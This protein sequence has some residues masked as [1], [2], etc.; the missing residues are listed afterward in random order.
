MKNLLLAFFLF[1][2]SFN[3][4][5][6]VAE[7]IDWSNL[8]TFTAKSFEFKSDSVTYKCS[9][10]KFVV[11]DSESGLSG[12][13]LMGEANYEI[14][15]AGIKDKAFCAMVRLSPED[16]DTLIKIE[17]KTV[18]SDNGFKSHSKLVL[19]LIFKRSYH[20]GMDALIPEHGN[21]TWNFFGNKEGD[22]L[23]VYAEGLRKV[24]KVT[25]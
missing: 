2:A 25:R 14:K 1:I 10:C 7:K 18:L 13:Y 4:N 15:S 6:Q 20:A 8:K 24:I 21:Y 12:Y 5:A 3:L 16:G 9:N 11:F 22:I 23:A 19:S 17:G